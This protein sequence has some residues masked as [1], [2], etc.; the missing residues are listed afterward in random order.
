LA[1]KLT[2]LIAAAL[3]KAATEP[4]G[5]PVVAMRGESGLFPNTILAKTAARRCVEEGLLEPV[6]KEVSRGTVERCRITEKG[7]AHL[8]ETQNPKTVLHDLL[9]VLESRGEQV[10][11][12]IESAKSMA[13][14][15]KGLHATLSAVMPKVAVARVEG[16]TAS[17]I[18][19]ALAEWRQAEDCPLPEL[20]ARLPLRPGLGAFHDG[21]R[22]LLQQ[23]VIELHPWTGPLYA[24]PEPEYALMAGHEVAYYA[25]SR[26]RIAKPELATRGG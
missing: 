24:L 6:G 11:K 14:T 13:E 1:D 12:L 7:L 22:K 8:T 5:V 9:R 20:Y 16:D 17:M 25:R 18:A 10:G 3:T 19:A 4:A 21:L 26:S 15:L 2:S 23:G